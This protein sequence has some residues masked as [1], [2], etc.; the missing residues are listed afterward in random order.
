MI[1]ANL[2][3]ISLVLLLGSAFSHPHAAEWFVDSAAS[4]SDDGRTWQNAFTS[5][6]QGIDAASNGDF[7]TVARGTYVENIQ[8]RGRNIV[9]RSTNP[10]NPATVAATIIDGNKADSVVTF[11]GTEDPSCILSGFTIY[12][13]K[14]GAGGGVRGNGSIPTI[15]FSLIGLNEAGTVGG[16]LYACD[17]LI[18]DNIITQNSAAGSGGGL[19]DCNGKVVNN[20]ITQN[21]AE[22]GGGLANCLGEIGNNT[23]RHNSALYAGGGLFVCVGLIR[24]N[25]IS[26]NVATLAAGG[27]LYDCVNAVNNT[28]VA[29]SAGSSGGGVMHSQSPRITNCII[30]ANEAPEGPQVWSSFGGGVEYSCIQD[31]TEGGTGNTALE[32]DFVD[33]DGPDGDPSTTWDN[34]YRLAASSV[35]ID[36][37]DND[38]H[39]SPRLD[40]DGKLRIAYGNRSLT[41]DMGAFEYNAKSFAITQIVPFEADSITLTWNSQPDNSYTLWFLEDASTAAWVKG[42]TIPSGGATTS[43]NVLLGYTVHGF[44]IVEMGD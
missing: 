25:V 33:P 9:L 24:N 42:V 6:Q 39:E 11:E 35:C 22:D 34:N 20:L 28:I 16:G 10:E 41:I 36:R 5:I 31:W 21:S 7:V 12:N 4:G 3:S 23:I 37:G 44:C 14:G 32:P 19:S 8:F 27:G 17:G 15:Q 40:R 1:F 43:R 38:A 2:K 29:N 26:G 13:G 30:W 18:T